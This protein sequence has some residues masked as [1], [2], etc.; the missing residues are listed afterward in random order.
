MITTNDN[1]TLYL[2]CHQL[3][4][5]TLLTSFITKSTEESS[6]QYWAGLVTASKVCTWGS[7]SW[8]PTDVNTK[9]SQA[10][11]F[12][13]HRP[14]KDS[15]YRTGVRIVFLSTMI[16][17]K[18]GNSINWGAHLLCHNKCVK[19][20]KFLTLMLIGYLEYLTWVYL[21]LQYKLFAFPNR[22][23]VFTLQSWC[24]GPRCEDRGP[25]P[26][27]HSDTGIISWGW[28]FVVTT[29]GHLCPAL[30]GAGNTTQHLFLFLF[31]AKKALREDYEDS[32]IIFPQ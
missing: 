13:L 9:L 32:L 30:S 26:P 20:L 4:F 25:P 18:P 28:S 31:C 24:K 21:D 6:E 5:R 10:A 29:L 14:K 22:N 3:M 23:I 19:R 2:H 7:G 11:V 16:H 8:C 12:I 27:G 17:I 1:L 15:T